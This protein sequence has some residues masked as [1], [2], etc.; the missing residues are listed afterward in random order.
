MAATL[1]QGSLAILSYGNK[2]VLP[3]LAIGSAALATVVYPRFSRLVAEREWTRLQRQVKGY[4][5]IVLLATDP[6]LTI[7]IF[8]L[9]TI[10]V[11]R[12]LRAWR[13]QPLR[14]AGPWPSSR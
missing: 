13:V 9:S 6:G 4:L 1:G 3:V 7:L 10:I 14:H 2:L 11:R 5:A 12:A 8:A